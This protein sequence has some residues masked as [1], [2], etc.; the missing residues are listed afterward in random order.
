ME[1]EEKMTDEK[2]SSPSA[3][4]VE[5]TVPETEA[6]AQPTGEKA[7]TKKEKKARESKEAKAAREELEKLQ[8]EFDAHKQQ[9]LRVLAEYDNFRKR[10]EREKNASFGNG[11]AEAIGKILPV[12]DNLE[13]AL[14]Q[15]NCTLELLHEGLTMVNKQLHAALEQLGVKEMGS[16]GEQFDPTRHNAVSHIEDE[17]RGEN[18]ISAVFQKGYTLGDRVIRHAMVQVAN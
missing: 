17:N 5:E 18:E 4:P 9:Y 15:E 2:Q 3:D 12:A 10:S 11:E 7:E 16:V 13:R 1:N 14:A 6:P 8:Q